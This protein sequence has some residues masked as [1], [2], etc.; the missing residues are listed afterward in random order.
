[1]KNTLKT[2]KNHFIKSLQKTWSGK[3]K[4]NNVFIWWGG[5]P[6]ILCYFIANPIINS[7]AFSIIKILISA[8]IVI[9]FAFH[10]VII[11]KNR[12]IAPTLTKKE[13]E[14]LKLERKKNRGKRILNKFLLKE[15]LTKWRPALVFSAINLFIITNYVNHILQII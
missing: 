9:Y 2:I 3:E 10:I 14:S 4:I 13:K 11:R 12:N 6:Y 7:N 8:I 5:V 1:M 15:P